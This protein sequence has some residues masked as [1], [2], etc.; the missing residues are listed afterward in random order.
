MA[1]AV[2]VSASLAARQAP[3]AQTPPPKPAPM[4]LPRSAS[5]TPTPASDASKAA[6]GPLDLGSVDPRL[7]GISGYPGAEFL[8]SYDAGSNQKLFVFGTN[9]TYEAVLS[10]YKTQFKKSGDEV[11]RQPRIQ[12][13]ELGAFTSNTM[14][15]RPSVI[16][17][18]YTQ[19]DPAGY[20]HVAG[21][22]ERRFKTLIQIIPVAREAGPR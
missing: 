17:K 10:F 12:Q 1:G 5:P 18:D 9:E 22:T 21:T 16:V 8:A 11:S 4:P 6:A 14:S 3:P 2:L 13:F 15:Q 19:P 20:L 7:A